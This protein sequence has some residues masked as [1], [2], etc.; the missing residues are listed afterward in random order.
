MTWVSMAVW[1]FFSGSAP[2]ATVDAPT[3][4][5]TLSGT[6][7][8]RD[9]NGKRVPLTHAQIYVESKLPDALPD[10]TPHVMGQER[11]MFKMAFSPKFMT[12]LQG[13]SVVF[14]NRTSGEPHEVHCFNDVNAF[15]AAAN[16]KK[17][18]ATHVFMD[19]G[20]S[21]LECHRHS[22][23]RAFVLTVPNRF[24]VTPAADGSWSLPDL[25][26]GQ[27]RITAWQADAEQFS[28]EMHTVDA[29]STKPLTFTLQRGVRIPPKCSLYQ[30][31]Q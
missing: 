26:P 12:V 30:C 18:T 6:L 9:A 16:G 7:E 8:V 13:E 27:L 2:V 23:M 19:L 4:R 20:T 22:E 3:K 14:E 5:C 25:P 21:V 31:P 10:E 17:L 11:A 29:C 24:H 1:A 15:D 28:S